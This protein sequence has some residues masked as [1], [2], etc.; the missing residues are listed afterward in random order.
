MNAPG[1]VRIATS[2]LFVGHVLTGPWYRVP[3]GF[4]GFGY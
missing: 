2:Y 3:A 4:R 1:L